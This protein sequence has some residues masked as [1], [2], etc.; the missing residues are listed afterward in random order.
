MNM[1]KYNCKVSPVSYF[2][3]KGNLKN[4]LLPLIPYTKL[5]AE[6]FGGAGSIL[7]ARKP[8]PV[9]FYNDLD[10]SLVNLFRVLQ[11][12]KNCQELK[13]KI[14]H[15]LYSR[16]EFQKAKETLK[17]NN[18]DALEKAWAFY[19]AQN[20]GFGGIG[21]RSGWGR[22]LTSTA[23]TMS[24]TTSRWLTRLQY[25]EKWHERIS[26]VQ[27][28][29]RDGL[30]LI[31]HLNK[32]YTTIYV[33]PPYP[34]DTRKSGSYSHEMSDKQHRQLVEI[35][36]KFKGNAIMSTYPSPI[37]KPLERQGYQR[38]EFKTACHAI[39]RNEATGVLGVGAAT[40]KAPR[41]EVVYRRVR[42]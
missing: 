29:R 16:S 25:F 11:D 20:Q 27:I 1:M 36:I 30:D 23:R 2:G 31:Q 26:R 15:T 37:Y 35:L 38:I 24:S 39:A 8:S 7:F 22:A 5:Y 9:E 18:A 3:G 41:T 13:H 40:M 10:E 32:P 19:V 28:E 17:N 33:D 14:A 4:K 6:P 12:P 42:D 21:S 34:K